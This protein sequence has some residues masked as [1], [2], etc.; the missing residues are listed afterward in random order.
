MIHFTSGPETAMP[1]GAQP[2]GEDGVQEHPQGAVQRRHAQAGVRDHSQDAVR[3]PHLPAGLLV[4]ESHYC[5]QLLMA[6]L[7]STLLGVP[8]FAMFCRI[9]YNAQVSIRNCSF[10]CSCSF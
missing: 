2:D 9:T 5:N 4:Q 10:C 1:V 6:K 3:G 7:I 8:S